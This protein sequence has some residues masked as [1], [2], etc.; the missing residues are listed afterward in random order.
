MIVFHMKA[1][2]FKEEWIVP[3]LFILYIFIGV[4]ALVLA[5]IVGNYVWS[6]YFSKSPEIKEEEVKKCIHKFGCVCF[7]T[8][9]IEEDLDE[10][11]KILNRMG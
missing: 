2:D 1:K 4:A 3:R 11:R 7:G 6:R 10:L 5:V 9:I 8:K